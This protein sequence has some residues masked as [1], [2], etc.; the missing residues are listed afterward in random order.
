MYNDRKVAIGAYNE[1]G[2]GDHIAMLLSSND[3]LVE[4]GSDLYEA[5]RTA[6]VP[7]EKPVDSTGK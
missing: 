5:Y 7:A 3:A 6:A 2:E 4:W 1:T